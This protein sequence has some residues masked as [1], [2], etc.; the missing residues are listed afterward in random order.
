MIECLA[1]SYGNAG[2]GILCHV[3]TDTRKIGYQLIKAAKQRASAGHNDTVVDNIGNELGGSA[4]DY[5]ADSVD[6][7]RKSKGGKSTRFS[8]VFAGD[9]QGVSYC[10]GRVVCAA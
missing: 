4:L 6:D 8:S 10:S 2:D 7:S 3:S 5:L 1:R 9:G